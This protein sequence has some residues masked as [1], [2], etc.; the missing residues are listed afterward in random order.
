MPSQTSLDFQWQKNFANLFEADRDKFDG[1][2]RNRDWTGVTREQHDAEYADFFGSLLAEQTRKNTIFIERLRVDATNRKRARDRLS[3]RI[4]R[5]SPSTS[6]KMIAT[7][8]AGTDVEVEYQYEDAL[9]R[10]HQD[11]RAFV[12]SREGTAAFAGRPTAPGPDVKPIDSSEMP[13]FAFARPGIRQ[14][15]SASLWDYAIL[16]LFNLLLFVLC[17]VAF[18]HSDLRQPSS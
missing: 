6:M 14:V 12:V 5:M 10:Y 8:L 2:H 4:A 17:V 9:S 11:Y 15:L 16:I 13:R 3:I 7:S 1:F 18:R